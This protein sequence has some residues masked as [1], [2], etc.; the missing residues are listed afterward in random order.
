VR[1]C[2]RG[3]CACI[4]RCECACAM[5]VC[6]VLCN[7]KK[8]ILIFITPNEYSMKIYHAK[9]ND[10]YLMLVFLLVNV[11]V[12]CGKIQYILESDSVSSLDAGCSNYYEH[13][14]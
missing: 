6:V 4:H 9:S 8:N 7:L 1:T 10:T 2:V 12:R 14:S 13:D 3:E 5:S 11:Y